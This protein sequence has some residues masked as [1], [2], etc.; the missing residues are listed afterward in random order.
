[1]TG[2]WP[3][4]R[5]TFAQTI[6]QPI[7]L[8]V[9]LATFAVLVLDVPLST[10]TMSV[11]TSDHATDQKMLENLGL[12]TLL[13]CG[14]LVAAFSA[15][16][17][18]S[19]E[20]EDKTALTVISKPVSRMTFVLGKFGGVAAAVTVAFYL[21]GLVF[22]MTVRHGVMPTVNDPYDWPVIVLG[23]AALGA[24]I[25]TAMSGNLMFG[26]PFT[27]ASVLGGLIA[28][29]AALGLIT[30]IGKGWQIVPFGQDISPQLLVGM[31]LMFMAVMI[32]VAVAVAAG[33][34]LGQI[35]TL[36][37]CVAVFFIGSMHPYLFERWAQKVLAAR[38]MGWI[39]P[40][41]TYFYPLDALS[42]DKH[43]PLSFLGQAAAYCGIYVAAVLAVG[44]GL[45]SRRQLEAQ[46]SSGTIPAAV[47]L[48]AWAGRACALAAGIAAGVLL[49]LRGFRTVS[50][51]LQAAG[52]LTGCVLSWILW[53]CVGRGA[54]W[55][56]WIVLIITATTLAAG[57]AAMLVPQR[58]Q[59]LLPIRNPALITAG[60]AAAGAILLIFLLPKTRHHFDSTKT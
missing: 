7:Y 39:A 1:M 57:T 25:V 19:R 29:S 45:F 51:F 35:M 33:T 4:C 16:A 46:A 55:S 36:L 50:G 22:L 60:A 52:L 17:A 27:S 30:V 32:L 44:V 14:L 42:M 2:F 12:S 31:A 6:R 9:I 26:W 38:L 21:C 11:S 41:L 58:I 56:Y 54:R 43:I 3:I 59:P 5:N 53:G 28:F 20:I 18:L 13:V 40:K 47:S 49:S 48:L 23:C 37:V 10:W 15:S 24:T 8:V 34:R